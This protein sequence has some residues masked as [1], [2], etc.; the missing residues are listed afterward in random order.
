MANNHQASDD[1]T[2]SK[3][4]PAPRP[5]ELLEEKPSPGS[6]ERIKQAG[7]KLTKGA[8]QAG[9]LTVK[10]VS[11]AG[12]GT[13]KTAKKAAPAAKKA[14]TSL[15]AAGKFLLDNHEKVADAAEKLASITK[16]TKLAPLTDVAAKRARQGSNTLKKQT[17]KP[18]GVEDRSAAQP[19]PQTGKKEPVTRS[20][21]APK[22]TGST[23]KAQ[24][25]KKP[26][27][28]KKLPVAKKAPARKTTKGPPPS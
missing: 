5:S 3:R 19:S 16:K 11:S 20:D 6:K 21:P 1:T 9:R 14:G 28:A 13:L 23:P 15:I 2:P 7:P 17:K 27:A 8:A 22:A 25:K 24:P 4:K 12:K 10:G 26:T 18:G